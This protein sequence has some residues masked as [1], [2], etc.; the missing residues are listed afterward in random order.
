VTDSLDYESVD[1]HDPDGDS[2]GTAISI[3][4]PLHAIQ[5]AEGVELAGL[6]LTQA[7]VQPVLDEA[8]AYWAA[9][10]VS[11]DQLNNL[12]QTDLQIADLDGSLLG[13]AYSDWIVL[14]RDAAGYGWSVGS[15]NASA[16]DLFTAVTHELGHLLG[17]EH[18]DQTHDVM[19]PTLAPGE[20]W[21][22][23]EDQLATAALR[24][25]A[26]DDVADEEVLLKDDLLE[27]IA[28]AKP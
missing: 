12:R 10:G 28:V 14:D 6:L 11:T 7:M 21:S 16:M 24:L 1:N 19:A 22:G 23:E 17:I 25:Q 27:L 26:L 5:A 2:N 4:Q 13:L 15:S 8:I 3:N 20:R 9:A 18:G